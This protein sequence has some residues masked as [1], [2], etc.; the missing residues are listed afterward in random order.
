MLSW[1]YRD[2]LIVVSL[3]RL[4]SMFRFLFRFRYV[5]RPP[6]DTDLGTCRA[7]TI[8][9]CAVIGALQLPAPN[10]GA[11]TI[12]QDTTNPLDSFSFSTQ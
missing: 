12:L 8:L 9:S 7:A 5:G 3:V 6:D 2:A 4:L 10:S 11:T 1:L